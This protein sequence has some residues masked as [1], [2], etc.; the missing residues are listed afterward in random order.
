MRTIEAVGFVMCGYVALTL[1]LSLLFAVVVFCEEVSPS[2]GSVILAL[3]L[4]ALS[5]VVVCRRLPFVHRIKAHVQTHWEEQSAKRQRISMDT[6]LPQLLSFPPHPEPAKPVSD[7]EYDKQI[8]NLLHHINTIPA[9]KLTS[10]VPGGGD[11]LDVRHL[12]QI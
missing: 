4:G 1:L 5:V 6:L 12:N 2:P 9:S 8:K 11:L 7:S 3:A 10:G